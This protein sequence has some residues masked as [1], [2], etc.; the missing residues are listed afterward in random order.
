MTLTSWVVTTGLVILLH[1]FD[2]F[3]RTYKVF[4]DRAKQRA[5]LF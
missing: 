3:Y 5:N 2:Q 4:D 1:R